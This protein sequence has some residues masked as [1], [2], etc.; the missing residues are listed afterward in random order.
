MSNINTICNTK[1]IIIIILVFGMIYLIYKTRNIEK[2]EHFSTSDEVKQAI[3]D[4]YKADINAI[5]NLSNFATEIKNNDDSLNI[6]AKTT[7]VLDLIN[8][9]NL[10][11]SGNLIVDGNITFTNKNSNMME[12][13]PKGMIVAWYDGNNNVPKGWAYCDGK[14][15]KLDSNYIAQEVS[16]TDMDGTLTPD[17]RGRTIIGA[18]NG[19]GLTPR[20]NNISGGDENHTL[21][22][23]EMPSHKHK[24]RLGEGGSPSSGW[25]AS[26]VTD[27]QHRWGDSMSANAGGDPNNNNITKPFSLMQPFFVLG[28]I[29]KL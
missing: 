1:D 2:L 6:P 19:P 25:N 27:R 10:T 29:I 3:S 12:I 20:E 23:T 22:I 16:L 13:F 4:I 15:Y 7:R 9:G 17:L 24:L 14:K 8:T 18:G 28:Y 5:R 21:D 26:M 11:T